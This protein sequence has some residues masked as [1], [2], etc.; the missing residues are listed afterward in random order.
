MARLRVGIIG[1]GRK[2]ERPD[3]TGFF[4]AY[5]HAEGYQ[6]LANRCEIVACADIM[7][8][9]ADAFAASHG[10][11]ASAVFLDYHAMLATVKLDMVSI[12][13]CKDGGPWSLRISARRIPGLPAFRG[14][15]ES[16]QPYPGGDDQPGPRHAQ[17]RGCSEAG[18]ETECEAW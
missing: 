6:A 8:A 9:N 1:T 16:G 14:L 13:T 18:S 4:M 5:R 11:P 12:C 17:G 3:S 15:T 7:Q 2:K 10:I